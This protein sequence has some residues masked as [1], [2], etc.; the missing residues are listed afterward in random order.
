MTK[1]IV[2]TPDGDTDFFGIVVGDTS[3][4]YL[5]IIFRD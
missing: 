1:V 2:R 5:F 4:S 3:A